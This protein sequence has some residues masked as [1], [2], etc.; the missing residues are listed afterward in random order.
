VGFASLTRVDGRREADGQTH[1]LI[2]KYLLLC[3]I[4]SFS[5]QEENFSEA[6]MSTRFLNLVQVWRSYLRVSSNHRPV[7]FFTNT[8]V[9]CQPVSV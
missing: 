4:I 5:Y 8:S 2:V 6:L 9:A 1:V 7:S 3:N